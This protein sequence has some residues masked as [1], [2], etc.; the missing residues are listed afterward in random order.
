MLKGIVSSTLLAFEAKVGKNMTEP[1]KKLRFSFKAGICLLLIC[2][3][4]FI[5]WA[6]TQKKHAYEKC[7]EKL[8]RRKQKIVADNWWRQRELMIYLD[9]LKYKMDPLVYTNVGNGDEEI[10]GGYTVDALAPSGDGRFGQGPTGEDPENEG[11][12]GY[13]P[14]DGAG[15]DPESEG[16]LG[17]DP[18]DGNGSGEDLENEGELDYDPED[19][20]GEGSYATVPISDDQEVIYVDENGESILF[21]DPEALA[22]YFEESDDISFIDN[23]DMYTYYSS[24]SFHYT[25]EDENICEIRDL[26]L[27]NGYE[28]REPLTQMGDSAVLQTS[29]PLVAQNEMSR[30]NEKLLQA[31]N[32]LELNVEKNG[33]YR[34]Y[35]Y[36]IFFVQGMAYIDYDASDAVHTDVTIL[37]T[38]DLEKAKEQ[39]GNGYGDI[40]SHIAH[41]VI[42]EDTEPFLRQ[43]R[44][45]MIKYGVALLLLWGIVVLTLFLY[46]KKTEKMLLLEQ[47]EKE[48]APEAEK[49]DK[50]EEAE[51][52][53]VETPYEESVSE[54]TARV[55]IAHIGLCEQSMGPNPYLDRLRDEIENRSRKK[56]E[57][58]EN[59]E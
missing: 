50:A 12:L 27:N 22:Q 52:L 58:Q 21:D 19:P 37:D 44:L 56:E 31:A 25:D 49:P 55:L 41:V 47:E 24:S 51:E 15:Y 5:P 43:W 9:E 45:D 38:N 40:D 39:I 48:A 23:E 10:S 6:Y 4:I 35:R 33:S 29:G 11:E 26:D 42:F 30:E 59:E 34:G 8:L 7:D 32:E 57:A 2:A 46:E 18:E 54:E 16:E 17:Y 3:V 36:E 53:S 28:Y 20:E 13:D 14:E 1:K